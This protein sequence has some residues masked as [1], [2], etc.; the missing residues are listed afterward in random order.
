VNKTVLV[1]G[2][3]SGFGFFLVKEYLNKGWSVVATMRN[4]QDKAS[5]FDDVKNER[6]HLLSLDVT[7]EGE[8]KEVAR[9]IATHFDGKLDCLVNNAGLAIFGAFEEASESQLR[10]QFEVNFFGLSLLPKECLPFLRKSHGRVINLSSC[11]GYTGMPLNSLYCASKFAVEGLSEALYYELKPHGVQVTLIEPGGH[12]T[13]FADNAIWTEAPIKPHSP[14]DFQTTA[15]RE[16]H[17]KLKSRSGV[18]PL[19]VVKKIMT[20]STAKNAP[21][22][23]RCGKDAHLLSSLKRFLP[24]RFLNALFNTLYS[25]LFPQKVLTNEFR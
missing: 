3:S 21:L 11:L 14:Y 1:T 25:K 20:V 23:V 13:Q 17:D 16:F 4:H 22:R 6:L 10:Y 5:L 19:S 18:S 15:F 8:R 12:R 2:C 7:S 24:S 9:Y